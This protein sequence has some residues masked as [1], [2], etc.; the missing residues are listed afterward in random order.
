MLIT[1]VIAT[2]CFMFGIS[3]G[4]FLGLCAY[5]IPMGK[6][7]PVREDIPLTEGR[8]SIVHPARSFCPKCKRQLS[9]LHV[10]PL[11]SWIFLRGRCGF[12]RERI[13]F[14]YFLIE[15]VSGLLCTTCYLRFGLTPTAAAAFLVVSCLILITV[16][17][18]DYMIIPDII[19]FP[20]VAVGIALGLTSSFIPLPGVL[21]LEAP[22]VSSWRDSL[23]GILCGGGLLYAVWWLYLIVR[24]REGLGLGDIKLLAALGALFGP[25]CAIMTIFIGSVFGSVFGVTMLLLKKMGAS[26]YLSFGPYLVAG[27]LLYI[28]DFGDLLAFVRETK[29]TTIWMAFH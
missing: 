20:G 6:Y 1:I 7:E 14:R 10:V 2:F 16:I 4:S 11:F 3:T 27:A 9:W 24:K 12:C 26:Q 17:D 22:F 19:T 5:R 15:L 25:E 8:L 28:F 13:P 18:I 21:P 23:L 29:A